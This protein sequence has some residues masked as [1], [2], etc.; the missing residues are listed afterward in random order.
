MRTFV[1]LFVVVAALFI[2]AACR[3]T[4]RPT[5]PVYRTTTTVKEIMGSMVEPSANRCRV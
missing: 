5:A 3:A 2:I 4:P 1:G